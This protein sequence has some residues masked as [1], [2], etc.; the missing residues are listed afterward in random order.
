MY[1]HYGPEDDDE[2]HDPEGEI[3]V[4]VDDGPDSGLD[5]CF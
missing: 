1:L 5:V 3:F 4:E 2:H